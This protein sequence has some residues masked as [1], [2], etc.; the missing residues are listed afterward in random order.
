MGILIHQSAI[1]TIH[2]VGDTSFQ[3]PHNLK[4]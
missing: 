3:E 1:P 2:K 4:R